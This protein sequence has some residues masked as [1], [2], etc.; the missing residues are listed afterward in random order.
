MDI[1]HRQ[2]ATSSTVRWDGF[3]P[4]SGLVLNFR[5]GAGTGACF[6]FGPTRGITTELAQPHLGPLY[7]GNQFFD[8]AGNQNL[9]EK[10]ALSI[11]RAHTH[12]P[13]PS[14]LISEMNPRSLSNQPAL[15]PSHARWCVGVGGGV[16][17]H[18]RTACTRVPHID[19][20]LAAGTWMG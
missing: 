3:Q 19:M 18:L 2:G 14:M 11:S 6:R 8:S 20:V 12:R 5:G 7:T 13:A 1:N 15:S 9:F 4:S 16:E 17:V 10:L